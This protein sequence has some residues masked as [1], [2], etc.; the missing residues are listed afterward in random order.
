MSYH[1][2]ADLNPFSP[3]LFSQTNQG[4][5]RV[6]LQ[7]VSQFILILKPSLVLNWVA[8]SGKRLALCFSLGHG[9]DPALGSALNEESA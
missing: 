5:P 7:M 1:V 9:L 4:G 2:Q 6:L 3:S 8:Q